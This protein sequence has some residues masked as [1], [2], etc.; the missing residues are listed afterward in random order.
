MHEAITFSEILAK[1][2]RCSLMKGTIIHLNLK[3]IKLFD[4]A[5]KTAEHQSDILTCNIQQCSHILTYSSQPNGRK[6]KVIKLFYD[7]L[8]YGLRALYSAASFFFFLAYSQRS[9]IKCLAYF[10]T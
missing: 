6:S 10:H 7:E 1:Y 5:N 3:Y 2:S 9:Q 8:S 4:I